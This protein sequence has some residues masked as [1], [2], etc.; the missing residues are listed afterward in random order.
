VPGFSFLASMI[1]IFSGAQLFSLGI[2]G[3]YLARMHA[4]TMQHPTYSVLEMTL[5]AQPRMDGPPAVRVA[6]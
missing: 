3:E 2:M 1:A 5:P 4:R 6:R